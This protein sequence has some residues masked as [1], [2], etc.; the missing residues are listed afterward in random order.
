MHRTAHHAVAA[1]LPSSVNS[2]LAPIWLVWRLSALQARA[3]RCAGSW[4]RLADGARV[5]GDRRVHGRD[6]GCDSFSAPDQETK[7]ELF[8]RSAV[9]A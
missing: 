3:V 1:I 7:I 2:D 4:C 5:Q 6:F 8:S 9:R